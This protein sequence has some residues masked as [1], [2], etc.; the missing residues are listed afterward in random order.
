MT[1]AD[2][3]E[4][5]FIL[6]DRIVNHFDPSKIDEYSREIERLRAELRGMEQSW[7]SSPC[8]AGKSMAAGAD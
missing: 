4:A 1:R 3:E 6:Q 8:A 2:F 7:N 5:L